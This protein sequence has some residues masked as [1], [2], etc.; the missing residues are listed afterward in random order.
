MENSSTQESDA[1]EIINPESQAR[2]GDSIARQLD[3]SEPSRKWP[4]CLACYD[5]EH[6]PE[7]QQSLEGYHCWPNN[8][9][10]FTG[11]TVDWRQNMTSF[12]LQ[13]AL[14]EILEAQQNCAKCRL[15]IAAIMSVED[16][17]L[18]DGT[19]LDGQ[20][21][22]IELY[23]STTPLEFNIK[24]GCPVPELSTEMFSPFVGKAN[25]LKASMNAVEAAKLT[26]AW[27]T[28]CV[29]EHEGCGGDE[30]SVLPKRVIHVGSED[31]NPR[32]V[33]TIDGQRGRY[34]TLSYCWGRSI[35]FTTTTANLTT[36]LTGFSTSELP[37]TIKDAV[38][39]CRHMK[40]E[41]L[42]ADCI[43]IIQDDLDD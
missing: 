4:A 19:V 6:W 36:R 10:A 17:G 14:K 41:Y 5:L 42:W 12:I 22:Q 13:R 37:K 34:V 16:G 32:L 7:I 3:S 8:G 18:P 20:P 38:R 9:T 30:T 23:Q 39:F 31:V 28:E 2:A 24:G 26:T 27:L 40:I 21:W 29:S 35:T 33:E 11:F 43:C 15:L 25:D 1:N